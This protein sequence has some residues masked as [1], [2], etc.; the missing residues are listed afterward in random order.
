MF[1]YQTLNTVYVIG[2]CP[3]LLS[4]VRSILYILNHDVTQR[5]NLRPYCLVLKS[6]LWQFMVLEDLVA[7]LYNGH[8]TS[9]LE[10]VLPL[11]HNLHNGYGI[12]VVC[13][14]LQSSRW[15]SFRGNPKQPED[16]ITIQL[17]SN[18]DNGKVACISWRIN[19]LFKIEM[20]TNGWISIPYFRHLTSETS[21]LKHCPFEP[22]W[23]C[24]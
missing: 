21:I 4:R 19:F 7:A 8:I 22:N 2:S 10:L 3:W 16:P 12:S 14:I 20:I 11:L 24:G 9:S 15:K 23:Y 13:I 1:C 6:H 17:V 5:G 18:T